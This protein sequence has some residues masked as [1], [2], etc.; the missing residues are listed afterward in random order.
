MG[1]K[2]MQIQGPRSEDVRDG[3]AIFVQASL[4]LLSMASLN[5]KL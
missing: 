4:V 3:L 1:L 5:V 2:V